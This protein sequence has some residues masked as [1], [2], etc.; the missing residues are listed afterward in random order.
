MR[1]SLNLQVAQN[2]GSFG[3]VS[4]DKFGALKDELPEGRW[5]LREFWK[6]VSLTSPTLQYSYLK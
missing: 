6:A 3:N 4:E 5:E 1:S 2:F